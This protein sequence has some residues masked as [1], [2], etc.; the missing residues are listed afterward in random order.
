[1]KIIPPGVDINDFNGFTPERDIFNR[2][3]YAKKLTEIIRNTDDELVV[4][5]DAPWGEGKTT[6]VK[7]WRGMLHDQNLESIYFDAF[8]NDFFEDPLLALIGEIN[9]LIENLDNEIKDEFNSKAV[10]VLKA[11]GKASIRIGLR[12]ATAGVLDDTA[13]ESAGVEGEAT[14]ITD[15]YITE[16]IDNIEK[17]KSAIEHFKI[18]LE[19]IV[20]TLDKNTKLIFIVDELDRCKPSFAL[21]LLEKIKH[22]FSIPNIV[23]ILVMNK[24]QM[25]EIIKSRYGSGIDSTKYLQKFIHIWTGLPKAKEQHSNDAR[26]YL[27][28]CLTKMGYD[29]STDN[30]G[31]SVDLFSQLIDHYDMSFREIERSLTNFAILYNI[32]EGR[33]V[34]DYDVIAV[35]LSVIKV[36]FPSSFSKIRN[37]TLPY[38]DVVKET[39]LETFTIDYWHGKPE[40]HFL[41]WLLRYH[42]SD[43]EDVESLINEDKNYANHRHRHERVAVSYLSKLLDSFR[44]H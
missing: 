16:R 36:M 19:K 25:S 3:E 15:K 27:T 7:M 43:D 9:V 20:N 42:I 38:I 35:Y 32:T 29:F 21:D 8:K 31:L 39:E 22:I 37:G 18:V 2:A 4:G 40:G 44:N 12:A 30:D 6:F 23:F 26:Y 17:D 34:R 11:I 13:L 33:L 14:S 28:H 10:G 5:L 24:D 1:M 41:K